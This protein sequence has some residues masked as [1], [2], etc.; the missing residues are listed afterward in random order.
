[1]PVKTIYRTANA[2]SGAFIQL[3]ANVNGVCNVLFHAGAETQIVTEAVDAA[4]AATAST[5]NGRFNATGSVSAPIYFTCNPANTWIRANGASTTT[6][7]ALL[8]W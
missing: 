3:D 4:A 8:Q 6:V 7:Y 2:S 5:A 1:M